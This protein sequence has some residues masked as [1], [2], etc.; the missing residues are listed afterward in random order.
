GLRAWQPTWF[1]A[2]PTVLYA[3]TEAAETNQAIIKQSKLRFIRSC[4][5]PLSGQLMARM[6]S[7]FGVP[8]IEAYG[9]TEAAH[10]ISINPLPP[11]R[12]KSGSV[13]LPAGV[14]VSIVDD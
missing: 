1:T 13:G 6:E 2:V 7:V 12:R 9:M 5:S 3:I 4:S 11:R 8:V 10:Q 14:E